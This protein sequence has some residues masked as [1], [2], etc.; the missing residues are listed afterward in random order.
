MAPLYFQVRKR[1]TSFFR[2]SSSYRKLITQGWSV[3]RVGEL[4]KVHAGDAYP[5]KPCTWPSY[6]ICPRPPAA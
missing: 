1:P 4:L 2:K 3:G 6:Q 5:P